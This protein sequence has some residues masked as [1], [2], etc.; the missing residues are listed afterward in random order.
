MTYLVNRIYSYHIKKLKLKNFWRTEKS[1]K[2]KIE[3]TNSGVN[4]S[5]MLDHTDNSGIETHRYGSL[6]IVNKEQ[7]KAKLQQPFLLALFTLL[8]I[9]DELFC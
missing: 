8:L 3:S 6:W 9:V 4:G 5:G 7:W 2:I 1:R